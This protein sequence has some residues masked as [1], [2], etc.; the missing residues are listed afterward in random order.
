MPN[1]DEKAARQ[2]H[3]RAAEQ[4]E[5]AAQAHRTVAEHNEKEATRR[6][7]GIHSGRSN[8]PIALTSLQRKPTTNRDEWRLRELCPNG[9]TMDRITRITRGPPNYR[10][11]RHMPI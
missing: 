9:I 10:R 7:A 2:A 6:K 1:A 4:H 8:T 11:A 3:L 5:L